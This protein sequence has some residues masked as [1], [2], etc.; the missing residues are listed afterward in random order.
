MEKIALSIQIVPLVSPGRDYQVTV[1]GPNIF[2]RTEGS[3]HDALC[4]AVE[5]VELELTSQSTAGVIKA[6]TNEPEAL[7]KAIDDVAQTFSWSL[8]KWPHCHTR[9]REWRGE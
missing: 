6:V 9:A 8:I 3:L 4:H 2:L 5:E 7:Q 1:S